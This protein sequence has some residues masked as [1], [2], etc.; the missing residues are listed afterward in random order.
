MKNLV[1]IRGVSGA[2]KSTFAK[3]ICDIVFEADQYFVDRETGKYVFD[4]AKLN[5][6]HKVCQNNV[7]R[8]MEGGAEKIAVANTFAN[9]KDFAPYCELAGKYGYQV[10]ICVVENRHMGQNIHNVPKNILD[11]QCNMLYQ[12]IHL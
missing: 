8:A 4:P 5:T 11:R 10:T 7:K 2:G 3:L 12:S 1:L 6:A 9:E